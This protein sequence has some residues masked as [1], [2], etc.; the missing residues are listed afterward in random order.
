MEQE[1][2]RRVFSHIPVG[3]S[4]AVTGKELADPLPGQSFR[5]IAG[6]CRGS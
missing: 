4:H 1:F 2:K 5:V 3:K 6:S